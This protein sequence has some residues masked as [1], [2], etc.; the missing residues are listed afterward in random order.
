ME[1]AAPSPIDEL[2]SVESP[3]RASALLHPLRL[4]LL[5]LAREPASAADLARQVGLPRQRVNYHVRELSQAGLLKPAGRRRRR[6]LYEQ[7]YR[8]TARAYVLDPALLGPLAADW[9][10]IEDKAS[11]EYLIALSEQVRADVSRAA[12]EARQEGERLTTFSLKS[13]FRFLSP[14]QRA[15]FADAV[16]RA[17]VDVIAR[18]TLPD[19]RE[20][21]RPG[22][23]QPHRLV[24]A[25]YPAPPEEE[26]GSDEP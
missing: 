1:S 6:N 11:S 8:A 26:G 18:H 21:G 17:L 15:E 10:A 4:R 12:A 14:G 3:A 9:R 20:G 7:R 24:L 16:R 5:A 23:G 22:R 25:C 13:Q 19:R 2:E